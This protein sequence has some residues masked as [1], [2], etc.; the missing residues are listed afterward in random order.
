MTAALTSAPPE[1]LRASREAEDRA[2][3]ERFRA[4]PEDPESRDALVRR[5]LPLVKSEAQRMS[6]HLPSH[7]DRQELLAEGAA[8]LLHAI[9]HYDASLGVTFTAYA[10]RRVWGAMLDRV[11]GLAGVPRSFHQAVRQI[12][13]AL[14]AF[15]NRHDRQPSEEELAEELKISVA[16]LHVLQR[17]ASQSQMLSLDA[18][19][20]QDAGRP[21]AATI[22][23]AGERSDSPLDGLV[24]K[25]TREHLV[26]AMQALPDRERAVLVLH[27]HEGVMLKEIALAMDVSESRVSQ[28]LSQALQRLKVQMR[29]AAGSGM[30]P[31]DET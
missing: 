19:T 23:A 18:G 3:W 1:T 13:R 31:P 4:E 11:R 12:D 22:P 6:A 7:I 8:G 21:M 16:E 14:D 29:R 20:D 2:A 26:K 25:E 24:E 17:Q 5:Y 28:L 30:P 10:R 15:L 9:H 27:F